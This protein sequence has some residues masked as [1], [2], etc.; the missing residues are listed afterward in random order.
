[1]ASSNYTANLQLSQ[2]SGEDK[3]KRSDF[4]S[5]NQKVDSA[6]QQLQLR[7]AAHTEKTALH[8]T[9]AER[10]LWNEGGTLSFYTYTGDGKSQRTL[11]LGTQP[12]LALI[13]APGK[14]LVQS[15]NIDGNVAIYSGI[16]S[17]Q[18]CTHFCSLTTNG[19]AVQTSAVANSQGSRFCLNESGVRY[20]CV[21]R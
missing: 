5:D 2:W 9:A 14:G 8:V 17:R 6:H 15:D 1:M 21:Y 3:P 10:E 7:L 20:V 13:F 12:A 19:V 11:T 18:G 16:A 4:N